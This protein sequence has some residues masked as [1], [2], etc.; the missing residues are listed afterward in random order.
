MTLPTQVCLRGL[1]PNPGQIRITPKSERMA[2]QAA[3]MIQSVAPLVN[4]APAS[5]AMIPFQ[6]LCV[7]HSEHMPYSLGIT[8]SEYTGHLCSQ[9]ASHSLY[10]LPLT[11]LEGLSQT[12]QYTASAL[13]LLASLVI[14]CKHV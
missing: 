2:I 10:D 8:R 6:A 5:S 7:P 13:S 1:S 12:P 4:A 14:L 3:V 11:Y 9:H